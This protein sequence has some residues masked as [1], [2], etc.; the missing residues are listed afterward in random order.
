MLPCL[1]VASTG[2]SGVGTI[3]KRSMAQWWFLQSDGFFRRY[4]LAA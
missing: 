2:P 4:A 3:R 1:R